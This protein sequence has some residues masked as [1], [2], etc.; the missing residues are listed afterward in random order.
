MGTIIVQL[1]L[2]II[3]CIVVGLIAYNFFKNYVADQDNRRLYELKKETKKE[4]LPYRIQALERLTLFMER[5]DPHQLL[6]RVKPSDDAK[7]DYA[8]VLIGVIE[9]EYH[10][11]VAQQIYV[12][13]QCWKAIKT[14]KNATINLIRKAADREDVITAEEL[15]HQLF[16]NLETEESPSELGIQFLKR[17]TMELW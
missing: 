9:Q 4:A 10:H 11:N 5:I 7:T 2:T 1:F 16:I 13:D 12:S 3:P 8:Q 6:I 17:E 15:R 14:S